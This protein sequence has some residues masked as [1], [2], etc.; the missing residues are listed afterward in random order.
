MQAPSSR[1]IIVFEEGAL[2]IGK[3][4]G[5][6]HF[7]FRLVDPKDIDAA[8]DIVEKAGGKILNKSEFCPGESYLFFKDLNDYEVEIAFDLPRPLDPKLAK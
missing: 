7:G 1:D 3:T 4:G 5:I 6:A 8:A 2:C